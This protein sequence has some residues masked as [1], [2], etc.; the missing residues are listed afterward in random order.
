[1]NGGFPL[2]QSHIDLA[3]SYWKALVKKGDIAIDATC[4]NGHD[5]LTLANLA[6]N[7]DADEGAVHA[8]DIQSA[9]LEATKEKI[10]VNLPIETTNKVFYH[11]RCHSELS[12][13]IPN[14]SS[15]VKLVVY[16]LGY[17]P[18]GNK[19]CTTLLETTLK[20]IEEAMEIIVPGGAISITC[21]PGHE[22]GKIEEEALAQLTAKLPPQKWSC[23][24]HKWVNRNKAPSLVLIQKSI[25]S[26]S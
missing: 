17:L 6:L 3:H 11:K 22:E 8:F 9:A 1:M 26:H 19:S 14:S 20:S 4:G 24:H 21:Y 18:G 16:N 13:A 7:K 12:L 10:D 23:C 25:K 2:F 5:T 15:T